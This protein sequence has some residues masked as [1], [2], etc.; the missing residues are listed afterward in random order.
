MTRPVY[1]C[2]PIRTPIGSFL[3]TLSGVSATTLASGVIAELLTRTKL[4]PEAIQEVILGCV[5]T[6]GL[7]QAPTRQAAIGAGLPKTVQAMTINKVCS[8][9]LKAVMLAANIVE[10]GASEAIVAG[11]MESMSQ[12]PYLSSSIRNGARLGNTSL[13]DSILKDG[14]L[15]PYGTNPEVKGTHMGNCAELCARE[16]KISRETQDSYAIQ[17]YKRALEAQEKGYFK[18][19]IVPVRIKSHKGES[20]VDKDEEP[21]KVNFEKLTSLKPAFEK[22]GTITAANASKINDGACVM[23]VCSEEFVKK[24]GLSPIGKVLSQGWHGQAPEWFTTAP[25]G[26]MENALQ[27]A[28]LDTSQI[29]LFEINEAF[30]VVALACANALSIDQAKLNITGGAVALGHPIGAS[31]ARILTTLLRNLKRVGG[32]KG[33]VGICNGGGEATAMVVERV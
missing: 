1:I 14:L 8:S 32:K 22:E 2:E 30:S 28:K 21:T 19:E 26:A 9:G 6:A 13:E 11:G 33:A 5:L 25:I 10:S 18:D 29:D 4:S 7:G 27:K 15:D 23:L 3:G 31:G 16:N 17:S 20:I 12:A 24:H